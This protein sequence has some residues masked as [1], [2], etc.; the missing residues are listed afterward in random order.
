[1]R[2]LPY[3]RLGIRLAAA[4]LVAFIICG[5]GFVVSRPATVRFLNAG[6]PASN[7]VVSFAVSGADGEQEIRT[8]AEGYARFPAACRSE[9]TALVLKEGFDRQGLMTLKIGGQTIDFYPDRTEITD[10]NLWGTSTWTQY[11]DGREIRRLGG[12]SRKVDDVAIE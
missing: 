12:S 4:V 11:H 5:W 6:V 3:C 7:A 1:M 9:L 8:D 10:R 2:R